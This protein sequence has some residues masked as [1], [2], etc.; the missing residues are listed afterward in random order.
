MAP[1]RKPCFIISREAATEAIPSEGWWPAPAATC[2]ARFLTAGSR[3]TLDGVP[4]DA[5][6]RRRPLDLR[7]D[8]HFCR[9]HGR[10]DARVNTGIRSKWQPVRYNMERRYGVVL[11][12]LRHSVQAGPAADRQVLDRDGAYRLAEQRAKPQRFDRGLQERP[13]LRHGALPRL[14]EPWLGFHLGSLILTKCG[15]HRAGRIGT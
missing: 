15:A 13:A 3:T 1:G 12:G 7:G 4:V 6:G 2:T 11:P 9:R 5:S 8:S 14:R 10:G